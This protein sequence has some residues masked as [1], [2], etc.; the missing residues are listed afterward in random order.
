[1]SHTFVLM[2]NMDTA[3]S[4][5]SM[6]HSVD[7]WS[8]VGLA[9]SSSLSSELDD[10][11]SN[12]SF[13]LT[14]AVERTMKTQAVIDEMLSVFGATTGKALDQ[15]ADGQASLLEVDD[16]GDPLAAIMP[17]VKNALNSLPL[18]Q[19]VLAHLQATIENMKPA[20]LQVG[21]WVET[22]S[23]KVQATVEIFGTTMDRVQKIFDQAMAQMSGV[24]GKGED[25]MLHDTFNLFDMD[26][27]GK[28]S[29]GDLRVLASIYSVVAL[30]GAKGDELV[31]QYDQ[32]GDGEIDKDEFPG[33]VDDSSVTGIMATVLRE[34]AKRLSMVAG[35]VGSARMRSEV[36][37]NVVKY[38]QLVCSKNLT[39]VG[40]VSERLTNGSLPIEFTADVMAQ[41]AL[42]KDDPN[43]LTDADVGQIVLGMMM[44]LNPDY[45]MKTLD[46]MSTPEHWDTEGF[47]PDD[48]PGAVETVTDWCSTGPDFVKSLQDVMVS[49]QRDASSRGQK[50]PVVNLKEVA[51]A[52]PVAARMLSQQ[53]VQE[54]KKLKAR[55]RMD[56]RTSLFGTDS[57]QLFLVELLNGVAATD[58]GAPDVAQRALNKGV[59]A[60]PETL[61]FAQWLKNN[62]TTNAGIFQQQCFDYTG[63][64]SNALDAFNTRI[65]GMVKK[66][67]GFIDILKTYA[68]PAGIDKLE[69]IAEDF[70]SNG[71]SDVFHVVKIVIVRAMGGHPAF[72]QL[73]LSASEGHSDLLQIDHPH[74]QLKGN[75]TRNVVDASAFMGSHQVAM[76]SKPRGVAISM[77]NK[78]TWKTRSLKA[79][80]NASP[81]IPLLAAVSPVPGA[82]AAKTAA[83]AASMGVDPGAG[84][85]AAG[86]A[87]AAAAA[88]DDPATAAKGAAAA[89]KAGVDPGTAVAAGAAASAAAGNPQAAA[90]IA[91]FSNIWDKVSSLLREFEKI[92]PQALDTIRFARSEVSATAST[93]DSM[94]QTLQTNGPPI[95]AQIAVLYKLMWVIFFLFVMPLTVLLLFYGFWASGYFGGPGAAKLPEVEYEAPSDCFG[96]FQTCLSSCCACLRG[97]HDTHLYM[98]SFVISFQVFVLLLFVISL[99]FVVLAGV[100]IFVGSGCAQIYLIEDPHVCQDSL[101]LVST[102]LTT[103]MIGDGTTPLSMSCNHFSLL[104]C[105][106][107]RDKLLGAAMMT[108]VGSFVATFLSFQLVFESAMLHERIRCRTMMAF[109]L[110][111]NDRGGSGLPS[112]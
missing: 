76:F 94:F 11:L 19:N 9:T 70:A 105:Q 86:A 102:F 65:Q 71:M 78:T 55:Q 23:D 5:E 75:H 12:V 80:V 96:K 27:S 28:I 64:S 17:L 111:E 89:S 57:Q 95:F 101:G 112:V 53:R 87:A 62:A 85:A 109:A 22:F 91:G 41:L 54:Y 90:A 35:N 66:L 97:C 48:Q 63:Q 31:Q 92:V 104:T 98:W 68:S 37:L 45:T 88:G 51:E 77:Y 52:M 72:R 61:E 69:A 24:S 32:D 79:H 99:V 108:V 93:M 13:I 3:K 100:Q 25:L 59:M 10:L 110:K 49:L 16:S 50:V 6:G 30:G 1:M 84:A 34:Y 29:S 44:T 60:R 83:A 38:F 15:V 107:I 47:N 33:L 36:S 58:G 8:H 40:W 39:K 82:G 14:D 74:V 103:L 46:L 42:Q 18:F 2:G 21:Q 81:S 43:V 67:S 20:L 26:A 73:G 106:L 56:R 7:G 4:L